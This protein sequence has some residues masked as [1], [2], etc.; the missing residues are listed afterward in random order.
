MT[1]TQKRHRSLL[2]L[3]T[4]FEDPESM[5]RPR[6]IVL[7]LPSNEERNRPTAREEKTLDREELMTQLLEEASCQGGSDRESLGEKRRTSVHAPE[8]PAERVEFLEMM[9]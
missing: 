6:R 7:A 2:Q 5:A 9:E 3:L 4:T 8:S 1:M